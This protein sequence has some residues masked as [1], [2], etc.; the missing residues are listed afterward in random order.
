[1]LS[2]AGLPGVAAA[3]ACLALAGPSTLNQSRSVAEEK[4][5][6]HDANHSNWQTWAPRRLDHRD[7]TCG[8]G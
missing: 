8:A 5:T 3:P 4:I 1:M 7:T 6:P 2:S